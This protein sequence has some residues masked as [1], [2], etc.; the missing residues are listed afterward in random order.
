MAMLMMKRM[1]GAVIGALGIGAGSAGARSLEQMMARADRADGSNGAFA[2][3][4]SAFRPHYN[5][6]HKRRG[7]THGSTRTRRH[8]SL[9]AKAGAR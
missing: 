1:L 7:G 9:K 5:Q 2:C 3:P 4:V 6:A 8:R